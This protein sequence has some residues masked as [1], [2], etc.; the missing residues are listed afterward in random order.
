MA[1]PEPEKLRLWQLTGYLTAGQLWALLGV[2]FA[3]LAG[4]FSL[5][6]SAAAYKSSVDA[7]RVQGET[8]RRIDETEGKLRGCVAA[9]EVAAS[10][11]SVLIVKAKFLDHFH[12]YLL[13]KERGGED[14]ERATALFV[15]F[16][17]RLWKAQEDDA[18]KVAMEIRSRTET[19][20]VDRPVITR[21]FITKPP[22]QFVSRRIDEAVIKT[23]SFPDGTTYVVPHEIAAA[24]HKLG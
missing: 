17:H 15:G 9:A 1:E 21:P 22:S 3:V 14:L 4:T 16:V 8:Q 12:R 23:V 10:E 6:F 7:S 19:V 2:L 5:G 13:A 18:V 20:R 11:K 24:V